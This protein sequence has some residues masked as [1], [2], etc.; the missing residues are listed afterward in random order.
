WAAFALGA[1]NGYTLNRIW[2]FSGRA[3]ARFS[4]AR[5][6]L[7]QGIGLAVNAG[8]LVMLVELAHVESVLAQAIVLPFVSIL[9]FSLNRRWVFAAAAEPGGWARWRSAEQVM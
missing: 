4:L 9:T 1:L 8:L 7:V 2:T 5:Y 6:A 3:P